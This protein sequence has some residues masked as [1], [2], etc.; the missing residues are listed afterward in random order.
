VL[1]DGIRNYDFE[2]NGNTHADNVDWPTTLIFVDNA[3]IETVKYDLGV[4]GDMWGTG[5]INYGRMSDTTPVASGTAC[6]NTWCWDEDK[7]RKTDPCGSVWGSPDTDVHYRIYA[8]NPP[9]RMYNTWFGYYA[10]ATTH[11]DKHDSLLCDGT[12]QYGWT[13]QAEH[14]VYQ[15]WTAWLGSTWGILDSGTDGNNYQAPHWAG[16]NYWDNDGQLTRLTVP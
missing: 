8:P 4:N 9:D 13:E 2:S 10:F 16:N 12:T 5:A 7:G 3:T 1:E 6:P 15:K 11:W 14:V